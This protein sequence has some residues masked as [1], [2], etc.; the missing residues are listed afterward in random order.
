M[1]ILF[2]GLGPELGVQYT[3]AYVKETEHHRIEVDTHN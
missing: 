2:C 1:R 3:C